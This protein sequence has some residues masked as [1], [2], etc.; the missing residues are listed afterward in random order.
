MISNPKRTSYDSGLSSPDDPRVADGPPCRPIGF[1]DRKSTE[2]P[3]T[4]GNEVKPVENGSSVKY[5]NQA[6]NNF[7][8]NLGIHAP[9]DEDSPGGRHGVD[10]PACDAKDGSMEREIGRLEAN[11]EHT[12]E[13]LTDLAGA[14]REVRSGIQDDVRSLRSE[15]QQDRIAFDESLQ[16]DRNSLRS[17]LRNDLLSFK[18]DVKNDTNAISV[19]MDALELRNHQD[20]RT[21][22]WSVVGLVAAIMGV[23]ATI[24]TFMISDQKAEMRRDM[25]KQWNEIKGIV[26]SQSSQPASQPPIIIQVP[27]QTQPP[28][29]QQPVKPNK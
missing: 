18:T 22:L 24:V 6:L 12:K 16:R 3:M 25:D 10:S 14:I 7:I 2:M 29:E 13:K 19:K 9:R 1:G 23:F 27:A 20:N 28:T 5:D 21:T 4:P 11:Q 8:K 15:L 17:E 26:Q